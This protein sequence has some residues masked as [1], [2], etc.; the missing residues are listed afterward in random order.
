MLR[1]SRT[2][3]RWLQAVAL[4][5]HHAGWISILDGLGLK[6]QTCECYS[7]MPVGIPP[8]HGSRGPGALANH[9]S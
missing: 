9:P 3:A 2:D 5:C 8:T 4:V 6:V 1:L 7:L